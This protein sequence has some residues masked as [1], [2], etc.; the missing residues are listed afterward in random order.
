MGLCT[1]RFASHR[2]LARLRYFDIHDGRIVLADPAFGPSV[3]VHTHLA[4]SYGRVDA[5]C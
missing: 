5:V 2:D 3:D 4:L 1:T